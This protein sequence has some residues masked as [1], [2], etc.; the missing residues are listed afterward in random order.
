MA[1][2]ERSCWQCRYQNYTDS[3][4]LGTCT[5]FKENE[6]GDNKEIPPD[7]VDKGCKHWELREA[8]KKA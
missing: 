4:F 6:K 7:V 5:W 2:N 1:D 8:K 3:T